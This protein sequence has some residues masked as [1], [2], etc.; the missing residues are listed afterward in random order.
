MNELVP[1]SALPAHTRAIVT[2]IRD[3]AEIRERLSEL[4]LIAGTEISIK[5]RGSGGSPI[6]F[7]LHGV[8]LA[9]RKSDCERIFVRVSE[10]ETT[11]LLAGN[12]NT[13]KSTVFNSLTGLHQHT[14]NWCGK[15]VSGAEGW[16]RHHGQRIHCIDTPG[17][18][19]IHAATAEEAVTGQMLREIRHDL[20]IC[21]CD[22]TCPVRGLALAIELIAAGE[23]VI[24]C[25]NL[26]DEAKR[27]HIT[28][29]LNIIAEHLK[30]PVVGVIGKKKRTL[31]PLLDAAEQDMHNP[32][33]FEKLSHSDAV[34]IASEIYQDAA[35]ISENTDSCSTRI[36]RIVA[37]KYLKYPLMLAMLLIVF[38]LTMVGA[39]VPSALLSALFSTLCENLHIVLDWLHC[40]NWLSGAL[41][42][43]VLHG[44]GWVISVML[45]PMAIFFPMFTLL[46]DIG[47]LPR[48][49]FNLDTCCAKC[50]A[51]GK[52][53]LTMIMGFGCNAV[54]VT[55]CR[56]IQSKRER[57][58][59][60]L[61]NSL[62]PCNGRFPTL[63]VIVTIFFAGNDAMSSLRAAFVM[64]L[65]IL[66][67]V[68]MTFA[69][70]RFLGKTILRGQ[71]SSFIL[72]LPPYRKPQIGQ[73]IL[74]SVLDRTIFVLGRAIM[75]AAPVSLLIWIF[76]NITVSSQS[77]LQWIS[78]FCHPIGTLIG[79]DGVIILAFLLGLP[80]NE[81]VL[82]VALTAYLGAA[83]LTDYN[84]CN[85]LYN[86]LLAH[87]WTLQTAA[88][89]L[90]F[91]LFHAPCATTLLT[92]YKETGSKRWTFLAFLLPTLIG[93]T[94]CALIN[95]ISH[96][97]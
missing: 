32:P 15:T 37:G 10:H 45:P 86:L 13:G 33:A 66:L 94:L 31:I 19:S 9:L 59:A 36:D 24:L 68:G 11:Y 81:I 30:I 92:I 74:R 49:A 54:G 40:P 80:A 75:T 46:E 29:D 64:T 93:V 96:L 65:L 6:A 4:G 44:T 38:W 76:A 56:I 90:I 55:E 77:I 82:P 85:D 8:T 84:S 72:E 83:A 57:L 88:C 2:E 62:V 39:N 35:N 69:A 16:F 27:R 41:V 78:G 48:I 60:I 73:I 34:R 17:A 51:C 50:K 58:I 97:L 91:T 20:V 26:M 71:P 61:T 42:D 12:P 3:T 67:S 87:G 47:L 95:G 14:G 5:M 22:A 21:V 70:S 53:A 43:G 79:L 52:Q 63:L 89:F 7:S 25:M 18:Y 28:P 1:L 23:H